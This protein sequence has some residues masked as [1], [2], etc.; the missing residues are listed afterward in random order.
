[1]KSLS[2]VPRF[3]VASLRSWNQVKTVRGAY[4]ASLVA[5]PFRR[6]FH[7]LSAW[8]DRGALYAYAKSD[9]HGQVMRA[10]R[11]AC[12]RSTFVF[13]ETDSAELPISWDE[14][15]QR[16]DVKAREDAAEERAA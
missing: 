4:G 9:P 6:V 11:P 14:A 1:L 16:L 3:L 8:E 13:W 12:R 5:Q 2:D 10:M 7:T 15:M